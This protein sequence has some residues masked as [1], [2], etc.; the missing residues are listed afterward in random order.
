MSGQQPVDTTAAE[1]YEQHM[2]AGMFLHWTEKLVDLA[3]VR[4]GEHVLDVACGTGVGARVAAGAAGSNGRIAGLD[5]DAGVIELARRLSEGH[6]IEWHCGSALELPF[7][8]ATF[9]LCLCLQGLQFFP[10]RVRGLAEM[11]RVLKV[12]GR[13]IAS[14]WGPLECN[15]GHL[16]VVQA[17]E[18]G[19]VD[20]AP[21]RRACSFSNPDDIRQAATAAGF[22]TVDVRTLDGVSRFATIDSFL[23][24]M[25]KG[26][27]STRHAVAQ[28]PE[29]ARGRF[30]EDVRESLSGYVVD[31]MLA[32]PMQTHVLIARP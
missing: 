23:E 8:S 1:A 30:A 28:L 11:R 15:K 32:Y 16:A 31:G 18:R 12:S 9:D 3:A 29:S 17:L 14:L 6:T 21:S 26:S 19:G 27:P 4:P 10:D 13:L 2:V 5:I 25:T 20:S 7:D 22:S 24:G